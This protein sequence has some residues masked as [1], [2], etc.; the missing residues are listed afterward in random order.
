MYS[1]IFCRDS[2][3]GFSCKN[4]LPWLKND[5]YMYDMINFKNLTMGTGNNIVIMG[6]KTWESIKDKPLKKRLNIVIT[7][8]HIPKPV[9]TFS[10]VNDCHTWLN[11]H[12]EYKKWWKH[13]RWVIGGKMLFDEYYEK[14]LIWRSVITTLKKSFNCDNQIDASKYS[15]K[16]T[17]SKMDIHKHL[18]I[19]T[20]YVNNDG[21]QLYLDLLQDILQ[22]GSIVQNRTSVDTI[23]IFGT[24][25]KFS[26]LSEG[27]QISFPILT[28]KDMFFK[29]VVEELLWFIRGETNSKILE[30]KG[31]N[32]WKQNS[33]RKTLDELGLNYPEG[34]NGPIYGKQWRKWEGP[35]G[36]I[37][38]QLSN[39]IHSL[40]TNPFSRRHIISAWNVADL[41]KMSLPPCHVLYQFYVK[42]IEGKKYLSCS[43]YQ[44]SADCF[45]GLPFNIASVAL[46]TIMIAKEVN[47]IPENIIISIGDAHIYMNHIKQV[48][49]QLNRK[50]LKFPTIEFSR[51]KIDEYKFSDFQLINYFRYPRIKAKMVV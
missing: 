49:E 13:E 7:K 42:H 39:V 11:A 8:S 48:K 29:G 40:K 16:L 38:D 6:R 12:D 28:T 25:L 24:Q 14:N 21:E 34:E 30:N 27:D 3:N 50:P 26:L 22:N 36:K 43:M 31:V 19:N 37:H 51:K 5:R 1:I 23:S 41:H 10:S 4:D 20:Y 2:E 44:R 32:I 33:S 9:I 17:L 46:F 35:N 18:D 45:L 15:K 47:M